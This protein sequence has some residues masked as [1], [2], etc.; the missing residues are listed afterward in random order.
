MNCISYGIY[1]ILGQDRQGR[2]VLSDPTTRRVCDNSRIPAP[3]NSLCPAG[4]M[5]RTYYQNVLQGY[6]FAICGSVR[7]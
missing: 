1:L 2:N 4:Y 3:T 6:G 7:R 5:L